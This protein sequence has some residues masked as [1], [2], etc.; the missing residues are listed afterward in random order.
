MEE[1][2]WTLTKKIGRF[3]A[4]HEQ[5]VVTLGLLQLNRAQ[6]PLRHV[7]YMAE[8][9]YLHKIGTKKEEGRNGSGWA[10]GNV[11]FRFIQS[12]AVQ[13]GSY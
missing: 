9:G 12:E 6:C 10:A 5:D 8:G 7:W 13:G 1:Y 3:P 2:Y 11:C 4:N